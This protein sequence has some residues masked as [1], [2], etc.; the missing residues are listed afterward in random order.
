MVGPCR[1]CLDV[2]ELCDSHIHP[3]FG[4]DDLYDDT[5]RF[6]SLIGDPAPRQRGVTFHQK[7]LREPL[8]GQCC[9]RKF[10]GWETYVSRLLRTALSIPLPGAWTSNRVD[11]AKLKLFQLSLLW[12]AHLSSQPMFRQVVLGPYAEQIR[13]MLHEANP[14]RATEYPCMMGAAYAGTR[15]M[16]GLMVPARALKR[17]GRHYYAINFAGF[18]WMFVLARDMESHSYRK[19]CVLEDGTLPLYA[20]DITQFDG[21]R[22]FARGLIASNRPKLTQLGL[23]K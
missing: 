4:Y 6:Y 7:G 17:D 18:Y 8:F 20:S 10:S 23:L 9:E 15:R 13:C 5:K 3:E 12:R 21:F 11:Y 2:V 16:P 1:L 14:G 19:Y 22:E